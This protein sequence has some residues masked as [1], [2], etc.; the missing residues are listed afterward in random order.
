MRGLLLCLVAALA[1]PTWCSAL[2]AGEADRP[3][4]GYKTSF[5]YQTAAG[6]GREK[7]VCRR[8][9]SD[10]IRV[11]GAWYVWYTRVA[12]QDTRPGRHG[13][14]SGY[15]GSVYFAVSRDAGRTWSEKGQA[16]PKGA[17][18]AFDCTATFTPN[19]LFWKGKYWLYYTAVGPGFD[20]GP[21]ADRNRTSIGLCVADKP[22][23]P[24][25]KVS[26]KPVLTTTRDPRTFDSYR[27][28]DAC[29][30]V[31][32]GKIWMYYKGRQWRRTPGQTKMGLAVADRPEGPFRRLNNGRPV[33]DSGH[34]VLVWPLGTGVMSLVSNTG[35]K[36]M[37]L[38]YAEDGVNFMVVGR[39]PKN[40]PKAP[41]VFR[42]DLTDPKA[43]GKGVAWGISMATYRGDPYLQR[44]EIKLQRVPQ[45]GR[46]KG[47]KAKGAP[48]PCFR[49]GTEET[50]TAWRCV[51]HKRG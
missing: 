24:W 11:G 35:P 50:Y 34:E 39:L 9:P 16:A 28:D 51:M 18:G 32:E 42:A 23:G 29:L 47:T 26:D 10:V 19:I 14:P 6:I 44:Y 37:T 25:R 48:S 4:V 1:W 41:G 43:M 49:N 15:Q 30:L 3:P 20:N 40:Y 13:Y 46:T 12:R 22:D 5:T 38:Q 31:R 17:P 27:I 2:G 45:P 33:Q 21:Y 7:G 36:R 8:D